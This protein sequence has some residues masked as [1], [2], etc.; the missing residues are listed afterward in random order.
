MTISHQCKPWTSALSL[1][2]LAAAAGCVPLG[3]V[4]E[5]GLDPKAVM[6][7]SWVDV[8]ASQDRKPVSLRFQDGRRASG[9]AGCNGYV[10][11]ADVSAQAMT[12]KLTVTTRMGCEPE[13]MDTEQRYLKALDAT[14]S[15]RIKQGVLE[16]LD[17]QRQ[18]LWRFK[19]L[20]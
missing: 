4:A 8:A 19:P 16:L 7:Q 13:A 18:V 6:A 1:V 12:F 3:G 20:V 10:S 15:A 11:Q 17:G 14:R 9:F 5:T 2:W